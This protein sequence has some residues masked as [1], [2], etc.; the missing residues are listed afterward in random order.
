VL[1]TTSALGDPSLAAAY[2]GV[3]VVNGRGEIETAAYVDGLTSLT[4]AWAWRPDSRRYDPLPSAADHRPRRSR[5]SRQP[6]ENQSPARPVVA[7][8]RSDGTARRGAGGPG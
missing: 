5:R 3:M 2:Q 8:C 6:S 7:P 1:V 4:A